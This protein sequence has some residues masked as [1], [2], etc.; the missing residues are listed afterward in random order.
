VATGATEGDETS[1][2][3]PDSDL[4]DARIARAGDQAELAGIDL[5]GRIYELRVIKQI[6]SFEAQF[7]ALGFSD[8]RDLP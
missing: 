3:E 7:Q 1:E 8:F 2:Q 5:T 4:E 6:E